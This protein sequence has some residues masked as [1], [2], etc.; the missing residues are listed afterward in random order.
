CLAG[1]IGFEKHGCAELQSIEPW[2]ERRDS[3][4]N[5]RQIEELE[6]SGGDSGVARFHGWSLFGLC[7]MMI[8]Q[9]AAVHRDRSV[10]KLIVGILVG[11]LV[12]LN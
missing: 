5:H 2:Q 10:V 8:K 12:G 3:S 4:V 1:N 7:L 9:G 6:I 11:E